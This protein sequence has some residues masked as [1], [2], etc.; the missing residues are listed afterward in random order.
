MQAT[1]T[2]QAINYNRVAEAIDFIK[3]NF[4]EQPSLEQIAQ[5]V[6]LSAFHFQR[7]FTDW[8]GV[9]PKQFIAYLSLSYAKSI[10]NE[11]ERTLLDVAADTGLSGSGRLHDLFVKLEGMSPGEFKNGGEGLRINYH[12][13]E[14]LFG[15]LLIAS[16]TKGICYMAFIEDENTALHELKGNF[17]N[18][19]YV[20]GSDGHQQNALKIFSPDEQELKQIKVHLKGSDFQLKVWE[21]LL[22]IPM[23]T[24][25]SYGSIAGA[26]GSPKA[27]RAV[28]SAIGDN[29]VAFIIPCHRVIQATGSYGQYRWGSTRKSAMIGWEAA[30]VNR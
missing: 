14:N 12:F 11:K 24:L 23:G 22:K 10:L 2:Q 29:P 9:S 7:L 17:P 13:S 21:S 6:N 28:G 15:R 5:Q 26:V 8:A 27:S 3:A 25:S 30:V 4:K 19:T 20:Q 18:A 1:N 16:T